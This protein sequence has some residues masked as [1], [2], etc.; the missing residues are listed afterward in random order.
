MYYYVCRDLSFPKSIDELR[1]LFEQLQLLKKNHYCHIVGL[2]GAAYLY[3]QT[4]AIPGSVFM[5]CTL[6]SGK[7]LKK[8]V[9]SSSRGVLE[10]RSY[11]FLVEMCARSHGTC[12]VCM[13]VHVCVC[14]VYFVF[15]VS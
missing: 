15:Y 14:L 4:F 7:I 3:K 11:V 5:V 13:H 12:V 10:R 8:W 1:A 2:F 9:D 6:S